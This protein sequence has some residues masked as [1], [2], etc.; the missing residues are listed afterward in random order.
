MLLRFFLALFLIS[1]GIGS[2][3]AFAQ[4]YNFKTYTSKNGL[5]SSIVNCIYQDHRGDI[6]FGTQSGGI[7]RF[8]GSSFKSFTRS[9]GL[10]GNDV[11]CITED[12]QGNIWIGT[13]DGVS[14][15][16]GTIFSNY[17]D[18]SGLE[19]NKGIYSIHVD[20][21]GVVWLGS[22]GGGLIRMDKDGFQSFGKE[23]GLPSN[24]VFAIT[25]TKDKRIWLACSKGI[26]SYD[27]SSFKTHEE[28]NGKTYFSITKASDESVWFGGTPGNGVLHYHSGKFNSIP[29]PEIVANDFIGSVT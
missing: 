5:G 14:K 4:Q 12:Q 22:R 2:Y 25:Q 3:N 19:V 28:S 13:S 10:V 15:F 9:N 23:H 16:N 24:N 7:S 21:D 6:W 8:N 1:F 26:A 11:T 29:L 20:Y 17:N 18:S 27:G